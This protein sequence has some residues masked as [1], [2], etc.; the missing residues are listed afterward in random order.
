MDNQ[1]KTIGRYQIKAHIGEG[2]MAQVYRAFDPQI[3]R[4]AAMKILKQEHCDDDERRERFVREGK[5]AGALA[6]P[7]IVTVYDA[8]EIDGTPFILMEMIE[9]KTLGECLQQSA[10]MSVDQ[11]LHIAMQLA[12]ALDYAHAKGV[13]HRDLKPDNIVLSSDGQ[14]AKIADF[15]IARMESVSEQESTQVGM[16]LGTPRYMSPEQANGERVDGRSDLF[17][18]GVILYEMITGQ[19]AFDA[20]SMPTLIMQITQKDPLPIR[21]LTRDA[22]VGLQKIVHKLLQKKPSRRFQSG[23]ELFDALERERA[24]LREQQEE[25]GGYVPLQVKWTAILSMLVAA[26]MAFSAFFVYRAQSGVLTQQAMDAGVSL[27]KFVAV[28]AAI[29]VLGEDWVTLDSLVQDAAARDSFRYLMVADHTGVVR[30]A[31]DPQ[32]VGQAW[33]PDDAAELAYVQ[34]RVQVT[35]R[36]DVFNFN[37]PVLFN[38]TVVGEVNMGLDRRPL[39]AALGVTKLLM[40]I[41]GFTVVLAVAVA[42][43]I[44]NKIIAKNLLLATRA[45]KLLGNGQFETR[46]SKQRANEFGDMF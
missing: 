39:D 44:F 1:P 40:L 20:E 33:A 19:K 25:T 28:Q 37:L 31:S 45:L 12:S 32:L 23:R 8:G 2:G 16:M 11:I 29:P 7:H 9:G 36:G 6:H 41:L 15:G 14:S 3:N 10:R 46:I 5:A 17:T 35:D 30:V 34:D 13:V 18:L 38:D 24:T 43:Y 27:S 26:T 4:I 42:I 21:Q 22:P